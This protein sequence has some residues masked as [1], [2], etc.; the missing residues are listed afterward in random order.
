MSGYKRGLFAI[1]LSVVVLAGLSVA[2]IEVASGGTH[3]P[4]SSGAPAASGAASG[5]NLGQAPTGSRTGK[6]SA[7][8]AVK[9]A[10]KGG[11]L[12]LPKSMRS[13]VASWQAGL[14][15]KDLA[16]VSRD[17][18]DALQAAG[19]RQYTQMKNACIQLAGS[20]TT[21]Q[22][23]PQI[24]DAAMQNLYAKALADLAKGAA[25]CRA[26]VT[27]KPSGDETVETHI[28]GTMLRLS[29]SELGAGAR[30]VFRST[31]EIEILARNHQ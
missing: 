15:G 8:S 5:T 16:A 29:L 4:T 27:S 10:E 22:G 2:L 25:D 13:R 14:G 9:L 28:N 1:T 11:A 20:V 17:F 3:Q 31:A 24:P 30:N 6:S 21:A 18:G 7:I 19:I 26:A 23:G 12:S